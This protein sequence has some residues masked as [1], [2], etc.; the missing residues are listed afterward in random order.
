LPIEND[1]EKHTNEKA[2]FFVR[3]QS[4]RKSE[5]GKTW[6]VEASKYFLVWSV[7]QRRER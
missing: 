6:A 3:D 5:I 1:E 2:E 7:S 4:E